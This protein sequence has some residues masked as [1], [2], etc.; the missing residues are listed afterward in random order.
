MRVSYKLHDGMA[1]QRGQTAMSQDPLLTD[2]VRRHTSAVQPNG[3]MATVQAAGTD[4]DPCCASR[5]KQCMTSGCRDNA[6][7]ST[8][9]CCYPAT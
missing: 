6:N 7:A 4:T 8:R 9:N 5:A 1:R 3:A 2:F